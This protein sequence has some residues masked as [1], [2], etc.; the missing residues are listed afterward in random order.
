[1]SG[2]RGRD[3]QGV[4]LV[5]I[6]IAEDEGLVAF[7]LEWSLRLAGHEVLGP[8][9]CI[10]DAIAAS[11]QGRPDMALVD[12]DLRNGDDGTHIARHLHKRHKTPTLFT[13][14]RLDYAR[15]HRDIAWG[16]IPKPYDPDVILTIVCFVEKMTQGLSPT[17]VPD[18]FELFAHLN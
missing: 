9:D 7:A 17:P 16:V 18:H 4:G 14:A 11:D 6:M 13:T 2:S 15:A 5:M 3:H 12:I 10:A 1:M 8:V